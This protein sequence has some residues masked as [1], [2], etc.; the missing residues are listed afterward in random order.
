MSSESEQ[1]FFQFDWSSNDAWLAYLNN[2]YPLPSGSVL[3]KV[4]RKFYKKNIDPSIEIGP[5]GSSSSQNSGSTSNQESSGATHR[6]NSS[7]SNP[8]SS[9]SNQN[10]QNPQSNNQPNHPQGDNSSGGGFLSKIGNAIGS[11]FGGLFGAVHKVVAPMK[12]QL[13]SL[14]G[15]FKIAFIISAFVLPDYANLL[16][17]I[18]CLMGFFRQT[19]RPQWNQY[20]GKAA[21]ENEFLQNL[22]YMVPFVFFPAQK[23]LVYYMPLGIHFLIGVAEFMNMRLPNVYAKVQK[24]GDFIR[25][26]KKQLMFQKSK[27]EIMLFGFLILMMFFGASNLILLIFYANFLKT[28]WLL[29]VQS[30]TA[31]SEINRW[32]EGKISHPYCPGPVRFIVNKIRDFCAYMV[33]M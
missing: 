14:E 31:F 13:Y 16:A 25:Q 32:I 30:K 22:F 3:E 10:Q 7:E 21:L 1:K 4:K 24:Y 19:G 33:K 27:L 2:L 17:F 12:D 20:Y 23:T 8:D 29:N 15:Y 5:A 26:N 28:K 18:V 9:S 6:S 11:V